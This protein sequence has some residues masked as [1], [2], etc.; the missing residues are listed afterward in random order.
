[1]QSLVQQVWGGAWDFAFLVDFQTML[2]LLVRDHTLR[3]KNLEGC[4]RRYVRKRTCKLRQVESR[5]VSSS[6]V[7]MFY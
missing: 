5:A 4:M 2:V 6:S 1:M 3:S 7:H